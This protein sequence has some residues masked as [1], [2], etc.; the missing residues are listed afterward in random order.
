MVAVAVCPPPLAV[1]TTMLVPDGVTG[2]VG[3][4]ELLPPPQPTSASPAKPSSTGIISSSLFALRSSVLCLRLAPAAHPMPSISSPASDAPEKPSR[5]DPGPDP[6]IRN[7][8]VATLV[9]IVTVVVAALAPGVT[10]AG[11]K[12]QVASAGSPAQVKLTTCAIVPVGVTVSVAVPVVPFV[13]VSVDALDVNA[14]VGVEITS[15]ITADVD[16]AN[17]AS[18]PYTAVTL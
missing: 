15:A 7:S 2:V 17:I 12:L 13:I 5:D 14:K 11:E 1:I 3:V 10:L 16:A 18:P 4:P 8:A 9:A 6:G